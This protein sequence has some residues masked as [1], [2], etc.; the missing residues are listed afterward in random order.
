MFLLQHSEI[1]PELMFKSEEEYRFYRELKR[2]SKDIDIDEDKA[3]YSF[4]H[5]DAC[6]SFQNGEILVIRNDL[7]V[8]KC[9]VAEF[10]KRPANTFRLL[11]SIHE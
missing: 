4:K 9:S 2:A 8:Q 6:Y 7:I 3:E 5:G 10:A 11:L 1:V